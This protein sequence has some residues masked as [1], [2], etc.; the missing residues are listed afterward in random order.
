MG[1]DDDGCA[2]SDW[3]GVTKLPQEVL[4]RKDVIDLSARRVGVGG[5]DDSDGR[6]DA[7]LVKISM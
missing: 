4:L 5:S 1:G 3:S 6:C 7:R 2:R